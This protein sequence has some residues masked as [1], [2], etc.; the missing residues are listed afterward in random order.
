MVRSFLLGCKARALVGT[1]FKQGVKG[2]G[3]EKALKLIRVYGRLENLPDEIK[4]RLAGN[5]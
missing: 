5:Y 1:D 2:I 3:P 4:I